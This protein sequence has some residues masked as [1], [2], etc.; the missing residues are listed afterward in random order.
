MRGNHVHPVLLEVLIEPITVIRPIA[1]EMLGLGLQHVE[2]ET[3]LHQRDLMMIGRMRTDRERQSMS[4]HNR[5]D[6]HALAAFGE[7]HRVAAALGRGKRR[8]DEAL[9]FVD[10][11][12]SRSVLA[13]CVRM[14][15]STSR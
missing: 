2:V 12:F 13:S 11:A 6:L 8:I 1:N 15:R 3:E 5:Q 4:I 10:R 9:A 7:V 14:S